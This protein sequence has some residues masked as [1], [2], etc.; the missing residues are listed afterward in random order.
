MGRKKVKNK[1]EVIS[2]SLPLHQ[3]LFIKEHEK[4]NLSKFVQLFLDDYIN[5]TIAWEEMK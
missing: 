4:F 1:H 5:N 2:I 3:L